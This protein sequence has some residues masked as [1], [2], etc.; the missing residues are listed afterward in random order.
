[1][2][3]AVTLD[4][5]TSADDNRTLTDS[6]VSIYQS[7]STI[8]STIAPFHPPEIYPELAQLG[9]FGPTDPTN[10]AY[11][12]VREAFRLLGLDRDRLGQSDWNP[13][14]ELVRPGD[15]VMLKPNWVSQKHGGND[16]WQQV[17]THGSVIRAVCDYVQLALGGRG[18]II[19]AD[20]PLLATYFGEVCRRTG[21]AEVRDY[22]ATLSGAVPLEL[23]DLRTIR[24]ETRDAVV[25]ARHQQP[26]DPRGTSVID[27]G[28]K[29]ALFGF[30]GEGRYYGADYDTKEVNS[31]H[32]GELQEYQL[33]ASAMGA[34]VLIDIAKL[35]TH[36]K[37]GVTMALKGIVGLN[38]GRNWLPHRTQGTPEQGGDQFSSSGM[39]QRL[40]LAAVQM[41]ER[42]SLRFPHT[43]PQLYRIAKRIGKKAFGESNKAIRGGGWHGNDT[44]WRTVHDINRALVYGDVGGHLHSKMTK[45]RLC[46]IDGILAGEGFGPLS[47]E[48]VPAGVI[49][50]G[51]NPVAADVVGAELMGFDFRRIPM[52]AEAFV[53]HPL[54]LVGF[55]AEDIQVASNLPTLCGRLDNLRQA[56]RRAFEAPLGW[57]KYVERALAAG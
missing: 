2:S 13:L 56:E 23:I 33:S 29:S 11:A 39:R 44:L 41:L 9:S 57:E 16:T 52:L 8:Y 6:V 26:G 20:G 45:R 38:C 15:R 43:V 1:M 55:A 10:H 3:D 5:R 48:A 51:R 18:E 14:S 42:A 36:H 37:V 24:F 19:L 30:K 34:D 54:P 32:R 22:Y 40:E 7:D 31:H 25:I 49:I 35:K 28:R 50:A 46:V 53:G 27:L 4:E 21:A 17:I 12:A 47:P